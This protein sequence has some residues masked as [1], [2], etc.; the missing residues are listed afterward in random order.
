M[1]EDIKHN[2]FELAADLGGFNCLGL[3]QHLDVL[4]TL[5]EGTLSA[6]SAA[7]SEELKIRGNFVTDAPTPAPFILFEDKGVEVIHF[8]TKLFVTYFRNQGGDLE[9]HTEVELQ[10]MEVLAKFIESVIYNIPKY[11][12]TFNG[13]KETDLD[14][15][16]D[17]SSR[18]LTLTFS[19]NIYFTELVEETNHSLAHDITTQG[20]FH[21]FIQRLREHKCEQSVPEAECKQWMSGIGGIKFQGTGAARR[22]EMA[23]AMEE[24]L[25]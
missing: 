11:Q 14:H 1:G 21:T 2:L 17:E 12:K 19:T 18:E 8:T 15:S 7:P 23:E 20:D 3:L 10:L 5:E 25:A 22:L 16:W 4:V 9:G 6:P 13:M 24:E